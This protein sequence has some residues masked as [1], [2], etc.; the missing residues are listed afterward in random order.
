MIPSPTAALPRDVTPSEAVHLVSSGLVRVLDVRTAR[1]YA[2]L[3]HIPGSTLLPV[4]LLP[5]ALAT[6][7]PEGMPILVCCEHGIRSAYAARF[8]AG[9][10]FPGVLNLAGGM[11]VWTGPRDHSPGDPCG[12]IGPSS[13]LVENA[14]LVPRSG[15]ALDLAC[16]RG[17]HALLLA[18]I[19]LEVRAVDRDPA[20]IARLREAAKCSGLSVEAEVMDLEAD[21]ASLGED[22]H[23]LVLAVHYLHRPLFPA[24]LAALRPGGIL[25]YETFTTHQ[26]ARGKPSNPEFL[27]EP[28]ELRRLVSPL[29]VLREREGD[30]EGRSVASIAGRKR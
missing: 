18:A 13:W 27:L 20:A 23:D 29:E 5:A 14:D 21:G 9:S 25:L 12:P 26:A 17:R 2:D 10:G 30:F 7:P 24:I 28:G 11:S 16:G 3:G 1:E 22:V 6:L 8:L 4:D 19:G 15:T